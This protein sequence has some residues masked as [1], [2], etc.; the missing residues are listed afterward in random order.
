MGSKALPALIA[1]AA[2]IVGGCANG[3]P[4][5]PTPVEILGNQAY[6]LACGA[7]SPTTP[8]VTRTLV[9]ATLAGEG[10]TVTESEVQALQRSGGEIIHRFTVGRMVRVAI[11]VSRLLP[12]HKHGPFYAGGFLSHATTVSKP[13]L[14]EIAVGVS[15]DH[16]PTDNDI[17]AAEKLGGRLRVR[18][19]TLGFYSVDIEDARVQELR[20]LPGVLRVSAIAHFCIA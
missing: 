5:A 11:D 14:F 7:W 3:S 4:N 20:A 16:I 2:L 9:D 10:N 17:A 19:T 8:P 1:T 6:I 15:L 12:L 13:A 18:A